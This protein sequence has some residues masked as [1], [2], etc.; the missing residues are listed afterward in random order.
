M[1]E[2]ERGSPPLTPTARRSRPP[3]HPIRTTYELSA[4]SG[5]ARH[6]IPNTPKPTVSLWKDCAGWS[7]TTSRARP[8]PSRRRW[9]STPRIPSLAIATDGC[10][11]RERTM[12]K[13]WRSSNTRS[14][15][16]AH[17]RHRYSGMPTWKQRG[18][19]NVSVVVL[20]RSPTITL[21]RRSSARVPIL[22]PP[23]HARSRGWNADDC[24]LRIGDCGFRDCRLRIEIADCGLRLPIAD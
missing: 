5:F 10:S 13:R 24:G 4:L 9:R 22:V 19:S 1:T 14:A 12:R 23:P 3:F 17:A 15:A 16:R 2:W 11:R 21:P 7:T 18:Y 20:R 8:T 6:P